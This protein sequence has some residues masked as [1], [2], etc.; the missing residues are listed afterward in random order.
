[1]SCVIQHYKPKHYDGEDVDKEY[2]PHSIPLRQSV[3]PSKM[4]S[5]GRRANRC[6]PDVS[7]STRKPPLSSLRS[8]LT[9]VQNQLESFW[10]CSRAAGQPTL[11]GFGGTDPQRGIY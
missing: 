4:S 7:E 2:K 3:Q 1:M 9:T 5:Y 11:G 8:F 10:F 6:Q